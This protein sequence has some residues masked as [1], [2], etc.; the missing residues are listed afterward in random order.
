MSDSKKLP[1]I[2]IGDTVVFR[3]D[4]KVGKRYGTAFFLANM[5][6]KRGVVL[7]VSEDGLF[8]ISHENNYWYSPEMVAEV[9]KPSKARVYSESAMELAFHCGTLYQGR[10]GDTD[11]KTF[12]Q[13][14]NTEGK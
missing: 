3:T 12:I 10:E 11:F 7:L 13:T 9:I 1:I 4:L 5:R 8:H 2:E 6:L 14:L